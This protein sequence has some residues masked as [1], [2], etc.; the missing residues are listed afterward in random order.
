MYGVIRKM[1]VMI[2][3]VHELK[4]TGILKEPRENLLYR[5]Y[6]ILVILIKFGMNI[7]PIF[8]SSEIFPIKYQYWVKL[9][10]H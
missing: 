4:I 1:I 5:N 6:P 2:V 9:T 7:A 3:I 10:L 8:H